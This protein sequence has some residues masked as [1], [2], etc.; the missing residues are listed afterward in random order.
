MHFLT[1]Q[2]VTLTLSETLVSFVR[3][4]AVVPSLLN[5]VNLLKPALSN[6]STEDTPS[7]LASLPVPTVHGAPPHV[8]ESIGIDLRLSICLAN[9]GVVS[10]DGIGSTT[11][12]VSTIHVNTKNRP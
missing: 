2:L 1:S 8:A 5:E 11:S 4:P 7:S 6:V 9:K 3:P 10:R 12:G